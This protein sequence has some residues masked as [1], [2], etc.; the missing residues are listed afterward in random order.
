VFGMGTGGTSSLDHLIKVV[1]T[2]A[3][4]CICHNE[5]SRWDR[6]L[7]RRATLPAWGMVVPALSRKTHGRLV[8]PS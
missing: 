3:C 5:V 7:V 4:G 6:E 8:L 1:G 2:K